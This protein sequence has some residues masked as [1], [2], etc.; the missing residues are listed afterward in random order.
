MMQFTK[1]SLLGGLA[2]AM[3]AWTASTPAAADVV[4][5]S[6]TAG[7]AQALHANW[8]GG[9]AN[10]AA[11]AAD[12]YN[13]YRKGSGGV[14]ALPT[15]VD[16]GNGLSATWSDVSHGGTAPAC[17]GDPGMFFGQSPSTSSY[18]GSKLF[19]NKVTDLVAPELGDSNGR[20]RFDIRLGFVEDPSAWLSSKTANT[21]DMD[22]FP[23]FHGSDTVYLNFKVGATDS[24]AG[25]INTANK[26]S[27]SNQFFSVA[28]FL[29]GQSGNAATVNTNANHRES[30]RSRWKA[31]IAAPGDGVNIQ[32]GSIAELSTP[33]AEDL[34][35]PGIIDPLAVT[36]ENAQTFDTGVGYDE[37]VGLEW[38]MELNAPGDPDPVLARQVKFSMLVGNVMLSQVFDPGDALNPVTPNP[39]HDP[40]NAFQ[41]GY[42]DWQNA[43]PMAYIGV[44]GG[45]G[46]GQTV[47]M[48][49]TEN[50]D[51]DIDGDVDGAD[52]LHLQRNNPGG[53]PAW[54]AAF[55]SALAPVSAVSAVPEPSTA[56]LLFAGCCSL[57][58][59]R[60]KS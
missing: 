14:A 36:G 52:F 9:V 13:S 7:P 3:L 4:D 39:L 2:T 12:S 8:N 41:D 46:T 57:M 40:D 33:V 17:C 28:K 32:D 51:A 26:V 44:A 15:V 24:G 53:I 16:D 56:V 5:V 50:A 54:Q 11:P 6:P 35:Q 45:G 49:F 23:G 27:D 29:M 47:E 55:P 43:Y 25:P 20:R 18:S 31:Q 58:A 37:N 1:L 10:V 30:T 34:S 59:R 48:G 38:S 22:L 60:R 21:T 42:F 19:V